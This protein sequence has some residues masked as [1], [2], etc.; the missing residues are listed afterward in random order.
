MFGSL[1]GKWMNLETTVLTEINQAQKVK[2]VTIFPKLE[3]QRVNNLK[4]KIKDRF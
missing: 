3:P 2:Y 4:S 1:A